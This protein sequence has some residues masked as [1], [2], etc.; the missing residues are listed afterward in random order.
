VSRIMQPSRTPRGIESI[1]GMA[2]TGTIYRGGVLIYS[3]ANVAAAGVNPTAIVGVALQASDTNP[4]Y[5]AA[6]N[7]VTIT[8][9]SAVIS[10]AVAD[11]T[12][13]Y[14]ATLTNGS[15]T[16]IA[17]VAADVGTQVGLTEYSNVWT[18]DKGKTA[19]LA[20]VQIVGYDTGGLTNLVFF[21]F[22][23]SAISPNA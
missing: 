4:G 1:R 20:R 15:S 22:L 21:K 23:E 18:V 19:A 7:P 8:G 6:N 11:R 17:P 2:Y 13:V 3:G 12:T 9:R 5:A 16:R 14:S 10:V